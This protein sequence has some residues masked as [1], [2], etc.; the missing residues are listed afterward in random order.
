VTEGKQA[1]LV[2]TDQFG[3]TSVPGLYVIGDASVTGFMNVTGAV[4]EGAFVGASL[5]GAMVKE[6]ANC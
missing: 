6:D 5:Q 3:A 2:E 1:G 4:A